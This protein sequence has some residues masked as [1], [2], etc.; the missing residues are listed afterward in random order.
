MKI[1][2]KVEPPTTV[3]GAAAMSIHLKETQ[4]VLLSSM[5]KK[6]A[7]RYINDAKSSRRATAF[8][9][10]KERCTAYQRKITLTDTE[11]KT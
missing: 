5:T 7:G 1:D 8:D 9:R 6:I 4:V 10:S 3:I 11:T 2:A